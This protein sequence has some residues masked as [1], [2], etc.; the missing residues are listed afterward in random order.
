MNVW[1][2]IYRIAWTALIVIF[3]VGLVCVF[4][5]RCRRLQQMQTTR[6][7]M[8]QDLAV[9]EAQAKQLKIK[10]DRFLSD[11]VFVER[12]AREMGMARTNETV[13]RLQT[14]R[15]QYGSSNAHERY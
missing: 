9:K 11:P 13:F 7:R 10:R 4:T 8:E 6:A 3:V 1:V 5:P 14:G 15:A 12:T 2:L